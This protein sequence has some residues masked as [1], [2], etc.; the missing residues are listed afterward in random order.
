VSEGRAQEHE[1][2]NSALGMEDRT[3]RGGGLAV[4][5]FGRWANYFKGTETVNSVNGTDG[6]GVITLILAVVAL[7]ALWVYWTKP[8]AVLP[9]YWPKPRRDAAVVVLILGILIFGIGINELVDIENYDGRDRV[10]AGWGLHMVVIASAI[11]S[12]SSLDLVRR[13]SVF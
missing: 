9:V 13:S 1:P 7:A 5:S 8:R 11:L 10:S 6:N 3:R 12:L 2:R 4:G